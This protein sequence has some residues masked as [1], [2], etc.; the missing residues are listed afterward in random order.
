MP[1]VVNNKDFS[2]KGDFISAL[3][4]KCVDDDNKINGT[5]I[6]GSI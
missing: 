6:I 4:S 1:N 5:A 2:T 3:L